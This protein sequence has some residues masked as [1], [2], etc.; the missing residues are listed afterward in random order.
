MNAR[1]G[2]FVLLA[3]TG[4]GGQLEGRYSGE[5]AATG[6]RIG[7]LDSLTFKSGGKLEASFLG[8]TKTGT[9]IVDGDQVTVAVAGDDTPEV[10]VLGAN[11]CLEGRGIL[12]RYCKGETKPSAP[13]AG[14]AAATKTAHAIAG[15]YEAHE[16]L[17]GN[18]MRLEF[19]TDYSARVTMFEPGSA[20]QAI[21]ARYEVTGTRVTLSAQGGQPMILQRDGDALVFTDG[22]KSIRLIRQ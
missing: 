17:S 6:E 13:S 9:Y 19:D 18:G 21:T 3:V 14:V 10:L 12:G 7:F 5:D 4:C 15:T 11:G 2:L 8:Q 22:Q 1:V 16:A 20:P